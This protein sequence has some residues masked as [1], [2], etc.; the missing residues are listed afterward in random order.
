MYRGRL[1]TRR[2][3]SGGTFWAQGCWCFHTVDWW[4]YLWQRTGLVDVKIAD[5]LPEGW[6]LWLDWEKITTAAGANRFPSD[7]EA[8]EAVRPL[9]GL[10]VKGLMTMAPLTESESILRRTFAGLREIRDRL[11]PEGLLSMGMSSDY[12]I[13]VEEGADILRIGSAIFDGVILADSA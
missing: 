4:R 1:W 11:C 5:I 2:Q 9:A 7:E 10:S 3:Q 6:K 13:A 8:L 12:R